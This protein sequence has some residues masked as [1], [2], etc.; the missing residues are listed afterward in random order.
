VHFIF[1]NTVFSQFLFSTIR[2][3]YLPM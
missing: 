3:V 2:I 1:K